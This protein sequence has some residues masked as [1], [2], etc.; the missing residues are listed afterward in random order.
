[1]SGEL[2]KLIL[3]DIDVEINPSESTEERDV[4]NCLKTLYGS[5][6][7]EQALDREFGL[8]MDC[9]SLPAEA[10]EA[11]LTAEMQAYLMNE[12]RRPMTD[13]VICKAPEEVEYGIDFTYYI[14]A[15]NAK[16]ASIVQE[17][18]TKAVEEFQQWQRSI[19]RDISPMELIYR[20]RVAGV[21]RV[22][23]RQPVY[24]VVEGGSDL[25]KATVQIPKLS[26]TPT[27]IY[28]GV[29]DD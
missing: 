27:I 12:A 8:N 18:V 11:K 22:E 6:E 4:Y 29:E 20:L 5:R 24:M 23:L 21:K 25:E 14:G 17:N 3:G 16:G 19:G 10:A 9:L 26:G 7:G 2:E 1:M 15:G 28:G 13:Q